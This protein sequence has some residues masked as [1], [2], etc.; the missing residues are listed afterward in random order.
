MKT[1][2]ITLLAFTSISASAASLDSSNIDLEIFNK[3]MSQLE[4]VDI[5]DN[6]YIS[7]ASTQFDDITRETEYMYEF[8]SIDRVSNK[9]AFEMKLNKAK[10]YY[11]YGISGL[12]NLT[13]S[14]SKRLSKDKPDYFSASLLQGNKYYNGFSEYIAKVTEY[15]QALPPILN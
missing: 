4:Q 8:T 9:Q 11:I 2:A 1:L 15:S 7:T 3:S 14:V 6:I 5:K 10:S 13:S 12:K